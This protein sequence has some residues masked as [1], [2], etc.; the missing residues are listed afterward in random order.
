L[1][2]GR[3]SL[4]AKALKPELKPGVYDVAVTATAEDGRI[5]TDNTTGELEIRAQ[6]DNQEHEPI[7][8]TVPMRHAFVF[9]HPFHP[10]SG[11]HRYQQ[12]LAA[13]E[14]QAEK[15]LREG[16]LKTKKKGDPPPS[17][18]L[19]IAAEI[20]DR[21]TKYEANP[22]P[23]LAKLRTPKFSVLAKGKEREALQKLARWIETDLLLAAVDITPLER[24]TPTDILKMHDEV[25]DILLARQVRDPLKY[26][27]LSR[28]QVR[29]LELA[30]TVRLVGQFTPHLAKGQVD[31]GF[32][33]A[34]LVALGT[35]DIK[36]LVWQ[37]RLE[38]A[39]P[40]QQV[41]WLRWK[42]PAPMTATEIKPQ[43]VQAC[44]WCVVEGTDG[45]QALRVV[46]A[47]PGEKASFSLRVELPGATGQEVQF[48]TSPKRSLAFPF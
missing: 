33:H 29:R 6:R 43:A 28:D 1:E 31:L 24:L 17:L 38:G 15:D 26:Q 45:T 30:V 18:E 14:E 25:F 11:D 7:A 35:G 2:N 12:V 34:P 21:L 20:M 36:S 8:L 42:T 44:A 40:I 47:A 41:D 9:K 19:V 27:Y 3:W 5:Y 37:G 32:S 4:D 13:I 10:Q 23:P 22:A 46:A 16:K 39:T 48:Q